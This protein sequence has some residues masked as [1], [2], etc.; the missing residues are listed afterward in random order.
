M[1][2]IPRLTLNK[3]PDEV[4]NG[5]IIDGTNLI[6]SKDNAVVQS[7]PILTISNATTKLNNLLG[8]NNKYKIVYCIP[9]NKE[10]VIFAQNVASPSVINIYRYSET[11][12]EVKFSTSIDY[13]GG[14][15]I[16]EF[17]YNHDEL[18][19]AISEYFNDDSIKIP[20]KVIN[21]GTFNKE[22]DDV[23]KYQLENKKLHSICPEV[24][25][26]N[27]TLYYISGIAY[28]G[29]Y[30][31]FVRY[32]IADNT[33]TQWFNTNNNIF[34]DSFKSNE[35]FKYYVSK[36]ANGND[37][38]TTKYSYTSVDISDSKDIT[39]LSF[40]CKVS[41]R[42]R[43]LFKQYQLAFVCV[44]KSYT[45]CY[46]SADISITEPDFVFNN[47]NVEEYS[48]DEILNN[49]NNYFNVKSIAVNKNRLYIGNY[50]EPDNIDLII[51]EFED[52]IVTINKS[53]KDISSITGLGNSTNSI[54]SNVLKTN[55]IFP[56]NV[57]NLF[58]HFVDK[59]GYVTKGI[60]L[61]EFTVESNINTYENNLG[62]LLF[63]DD[64][65]FDF[66]TKTFNATVSLNKF[67]TGYIGYF[68][69]YEKVE[70]RVKYIG[71]AANN[72]VHAERKSILFYT[73]RFNY[74][75]A[76]DFDF[77]TI[78][79][80]STKNDY[81]D[82]ETPNQNITA[83]LTLLSEEYQEYTIIDKL[84]YVADSFDNIGFS[85]K[86]VLTLNN[87]TSLRNN[88]IAILLKSSKTDYYNKKNKTLIPCT[89][90]IYQVGSSITVKNDLRINNCFISNNHALIYRGSFFN[91]TLKIFQLEQDTT[92]YFIP[93]INNIFLAPI[94]IPMESLQFNNNPVVTFFP[95]DGLNTTDEN[96]KSFSIG[97]IVECKNSIDLYQQKNTSIYESYPKSL[98]WY[99]KD[100]KYTNDFP[101]TIRR[102]NI[103][104]DES[105][106][107]SWRH[108]DT[109]NYKI[110]TENKGNIVKL[111]SIGYYFIVHTQHSMFLFNAT[112]TINS[113]ENN[114][115]LAS[116]D[117]WD[118]DYKEVVTS[119][120]GFAGIQKEYNG[121]IGEFGYIFYDS[122]ARRIYKYDNNQ[123]SYIDKDVINFIHKLYGYNVHLFDDKLRDRI[124]FRFFKDG[125]DDIVL[126][127][128]YNTNT[129]ISR[130]L[131]NFYR[132][133]STKERTYVVS[134]YS[135]ESIYSVINEYSDKL[136]NDVT[137]NIMINDN[138]YDMKY[139][140]YIAYNLNKVVEQMLSLH[141]PVEGLSKHYAGDY[142]RVYTANCDTGDLDVTFVNPETTINSTMDYTKP[143][144]RFGNWHFN[145]LRDKLAQY[146]KGNVV[147]EDSS[148]IYGNWF[149]VKFTCLGQQAV[150][151]ESIDAKLINGEK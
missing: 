57:Y 130:H 143:Y 133:W 66:T 98:D 85:T 99:D 141:L 139:M 62:N 96:N 37:S 38:G 54:T 22:I 53:Y 32:K 19:I 35:F 50:K 55:S 25:I 127:Y 21:L 86:L 20:L 18:I 58:I 3:H 112:D 125:V 23:N 109:E 142:L 140:E 89:D 84:L 72:G 78:R 11:T 45:K 73:D 43:S 90:V 92:A 7:E 52:I 75:D 95:I 33:Y 13:A 110:I 136:Y 115:Q 134:K 31:V 151:F 39:T 101:K 47:S 100:I 14:N 94:E 80:Y 107:I 27:V 129:F 40:R 135:D 29:W 71:V 41:N 147:A 83:N 97:S 150:E 88:S 79:I 106:E 126:S 76:I 103:I 81:T 138:Y 15:I 149:V 117:I 70:S 30:Y 119:N 63:C 121:I 24:L 17:T 93:C 59:Y 51:N 131:Y 16:G 28:K 64:E 1:K 48:I 91:N 102:S 128:N 145:A 122:D 118:I 9:C 5:S 111:I 123:V 56:F 74:D 113:K 65:T 10:L 124:L 6:V 8:A 87:S 148:R 132:G 2:I 77:D 69:S 49:Y 36:D 146:I 137:I 46:K 144:W 82:S 34:I 116:I 120:L 61:S 105:N 4:I 12:D 60:N 67:P 68:I 108:F 44:S 104:Q 42:D 114:I 26:S